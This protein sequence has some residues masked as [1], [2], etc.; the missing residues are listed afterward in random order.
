M[1]RFATY[2]TN[3]G[4]NAKDK[5]TYSGLI[6]ASELEDS[7]RYETV[8]STIEQLGTFFAANY[9]STD[10]LNYDL[11][12]IT[13]R[14]STL[15]QQTESD[16]VFALWDRSTGIEITK[17]QITDYSVPTLDSVLTSGNTS[18]NNITIGAINIDWA[19]SNNN[20]IYQSG[21]DS[22]GNT[23]WGKIWPAGPSRKMTFD[24]YYTQGGGYDFRYNGANIMT[25]SSEGWLRPNY[26][27]VEN[28]TTTKT[29]VIS[30]YA[31]LNF[32][33]D[34]A[35]AAGGVELGGI[36]HT[37]GVLKIRIT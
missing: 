12:N 1:A 11:G 3:S 4:I 34:A 30:D 31:N 7:L 21:I 26:L 32:A 9:F 25:L 37:S 36:Y 29:L 33:D 6:E 22:Y 16:P 18:T 2:S 14:I 23:I 19:I 20:N 27:T 17:S 10:D 35:A 13:S 8:S 24:T 5:I 15:E 28:K